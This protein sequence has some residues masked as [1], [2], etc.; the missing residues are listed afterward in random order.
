MAHGDCIFLT[1]ITG[2]V[3][4][5]VAAEALRRGYRITALVRGSDPPAARRRVESVLATAGASDLADRVEILAG[6]VESDGLGIDLGEPAVRAARQVIHC[7]GCTEFR[8]TSAD[9]LW[10]TNV[11]GARHVLAVAQAL[12]LPL[13]HVSTAYV[14]GSRGGTAREDELDPQAAFNN[15]YERSKAAGEALVRGWREQ[16]GLPAIIL[17]PSIV[18]GDS[19][20][21]RTV[22]F[23]TVYHIM[24]T[25]DIVS[26]DAGDAELRI[27][28]DPTAT[29]N[30][31][32]VDYFI[33]LAW[34]LIERGVPGTYHLTH[35][36]PMP[37]G[38]LRDIFA[39]LFGLPGIRLVD[40]KDFERRPPTDL[41]QLY[42]N[43]SAAYLPYM[44]SE[45]HFDRSGTDRVLAGALPEPP[46]LDPAYFAR[47]LDFARARRWRRPSDE[48][49]RR[50]ADAAPAD[51]ARYFSDF[52]AG[53]MHRL[54][55]PDLH[56]L[57][58]TFAIVIRGVPRGRWV[59]AVESGRL[60]AVHRDGQPA[61][62]TFL[63]EPRVF[64]EIVAGR[65]SP[66]QAFFERQVDIEGDLETGLKTA[67]VLSAFFKQFPF[68]AGGN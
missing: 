2:S 9:L 54:L 22:G 63:T 33:A 59:L 31:L 15:A 49:F 24:R 65:M 38:R 17:R 19:A 55:L 67:T 32:P 39:E 29:K 25:L 10:R 40:A 14:A 42:Q 11:E 12:R 60:M 30:F 4:A 58:A 51:V 7:A 23:T 66:Q 1:G 50:S 36:Q 46:P 64:L 53:K 45:P 41:E 6:D 16:T 27:L 21:G 52:L 20:G 62:C 26:R 28:A 34:G 3:G 57:T 37:F 56:S 5:W 8:D 68:A 44:M 18:I 48:P 61:R 43:A 13:V 47:L 35:P